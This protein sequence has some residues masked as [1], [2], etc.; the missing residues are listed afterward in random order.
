[1]GYTYYVSTQG[2]DISGDG[3]SEN[4]WQTIQYALSHMQGGDTLILKNGT[5]NNPKD[6]IDF[7]HVPSGSEKAYTTIRAETDWDVTI[8]YHFLFKKRHTFV[9]I[10]VTS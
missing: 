6:Q 2:N 10:A 3:T 4:P 9:W 8:E 1:M 7:Y 5:Y